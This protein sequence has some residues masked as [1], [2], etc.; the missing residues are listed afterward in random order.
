MAS[1]STQ[2]GAK[3]T[4]RRTESGSRRSV[5]THAAGGR[6]VRKTPASPSRRK[7]TGT[8]A[9]SAWRSYLVPVSIV[10]VL[11]LSAWSFYP[12]ARLNYTEERERAR[13]AA[14]LDGLKERNEVLRSQ[15]DR[16]KTP[17]GVEEVAR[18]NLGMVKEGENLVVIV[19][20]EAEQRPAV[21]TP[22]TAAAVPQPEPSAWQQVLDALFGL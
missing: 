11:V 2:H 19:D 5:R 10:A 6:P 21:L 14:E 8:P 3:A 15:V 9:A 12:V 1:R 16:L 4:K 20:D 7:Q 17:E 13:L 18:E 22:D